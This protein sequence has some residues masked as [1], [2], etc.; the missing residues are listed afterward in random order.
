MHPN[1][2][3]HTHGQADLAQPK[4]QIPNHPYQTT[5]SHTLVPKRQLLLMQPIHDPH[6]P[7]N[8]PAA[9]LGRIQLQSSPFVGFLLE[10]LYMLV[11]F[12]KHKLA[13]LKVAGS[14][15]KT[16]GLEKIV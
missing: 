10:G 2:V 16:S 8:N 14:F 15:E 4:S 5:Y 7:C 1:Y 11:G 12:F 9:W 3:L 6:T 13:I